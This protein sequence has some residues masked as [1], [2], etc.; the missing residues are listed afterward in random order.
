MA[1]GIELLERGPVARTWILLAVT[2]IFLGSIPDCAIAQGP[3]DAAASRSAKAAPSRAFS[4]SANPL[5]RII[6]IR[7]GIAGQYKAGLWTPVRVLLEGGAEP[8]AGQVSVVAPDGDGVPCRFSTPV[9]KPCV[10]GP[11]ETATVEFCARLGRAEPVLTVQLHQPRD[12]SPESQRVFKVGD[13]EPPSVLRRALRSTEGLIVVAGAEPAWAERTLTGLRQL[14]GGRT[15]VARVAEIAELPERWE[16]Y[17]GV[18]AVVLATGDVAA[19][20]GTRSDSPQIAA[21]EQW[22]RLGGSLLVCAGRN[23]GATIAEGAPLAR[24]APGRFTRTVPL[25]QSSAIEAYCASAVPI[26]REGPGQHLELRVPQFAG[27]E[28]TIEAREGNLPLVVRRAL[29][30]GGIVFAAFDLDQLP[31]FDPD[32]HAGRERR[33]R[34]WQDLGSLIG[35]LLDAEESSVE[36]AKPAGA[37]LHYGFDDM[38]GQLRSALEQFS[39]LPVVPFWIVVALVVVY[40][41]LIG[42]GDYFFLRKVVGRMTATWITFPLV[43]AVFSAGAFLLAHRLKGD[44]VRVNQVDLVDMDLPSGEVRGTSWATVFSPRAQRSDVA[45]E[46]QG[47]VE[48]RQ[49]GPATTGS[50]APPHAARDVKTCW[51]G[52]PGEGFGGM[53]PKTLSAT[54]WKDG[55]A[56]SPRLDAL[57][58]VPMPTWS[59]RSFTARWHVKTEVRPEARI[60][61][62]D[63]IPVGVITNTLGV[64]LAECLLC[65]ARWAYR[66]GDL[67]PG[68]S[69]AVGPTSER[70]D[71][72]T[73]LTG[74]RLLFE[75]GVQRATPYD[76]GSSDVTYI[77]RAMMFFKAA[78]GHRYTG[79]ANRYQGFVDLSD[80]LKN[81]RAILMAIGPNS[82]GPSCR[83]GARLLYQGQPA[84]GAEDRHMTIYRFV[85]PVAKEGESR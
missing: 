7:V 80:L 29:G 55:Y 66:L 79:L 32:F 23:A 63:R 47:F 50:A 82:D 12:D 68:E 2:G 17:E 61:E 16:G 60:A 67:G 35:K 77:L 65:Y 33:D 5:P 59:T 48:S 52:L 37:V 4:A 28:G 41:V 53:D 20:R 36:A 43:V 51:L 1:I 76:R 15:Q 62:K 49:P 39:D 64:P 75:A 13:V 18:D 8:W 81:D 56:C 70:R 10:V 3:S 44:Q 85:I 25:R 84:A 72:T 58:G 24:F 9:E 22:V 11:G 45:F 69:V 21:L 26:P 46:P 73:L 74:R 6:A 34:G 78:G 42:P 83:P 31:L 30:F 27:L 71:L 38:S 54:L 57:W 40:L 14:A 19:Y